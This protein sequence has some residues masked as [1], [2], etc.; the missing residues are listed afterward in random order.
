MSLKGLFSSTLAGTENWQIEQG[1]PGGEGFYTSTAQM[2]N[3]TGILVVANANSG[4]IV[5]P[6]GAGIVNAYSTIVF[7]VASV[8]ATLNLPATPLDGQI[9]ELINGSAGAFTQLT[10]AQ[11]DGSTLVGTATTGALA[12]GASAEWR[13]AASNNTWY[14]VR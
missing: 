1:G 6:S 10:F 13:Y 8:S 9:V 2:R 11:T 3:C 7:T 14:R 12:I 4:T 5:W